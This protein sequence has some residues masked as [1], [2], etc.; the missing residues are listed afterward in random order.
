MAAPLASGGSK[1]QYLNLEIKYP[2]TIPGFIGSYP[3]ME[4]PIGLITIDISNY[5]QK[6]LPFNII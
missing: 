5:R 3:K 1:Y 6:I 4:E 2:K